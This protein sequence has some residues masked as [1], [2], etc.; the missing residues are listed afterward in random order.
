MTIDESSGRARPECI[1]LPVRAGATPAGK[2]TVRIFLG[3]E[4]AQFRANRVFLWSIE[5]VRDPGREYEIYFMSEL[6]GFDRHGWTTGFTNY[7]FAIPHLAGERG[8]AIYNDEDQIYLRDPGELFDLDLDG[9]G[10]L[11]ISDTETSVMLIDCERMAKLWTLE[12]AQRVRKKAILRKTLRVPRIRGELDPHWNARDEEFVAGRSMCLHYT[13]LHMQPWRPFPERFAYL[14]NPHEDLWLE[15]ERSSIAAGYDIFERRRPTQGF[16]EGLACLERGETRRVGAPAVQETLARDLRG[17]VERSGARS[18]LEVAPLRDDGENGEKASRVEVWNEAPLRATLT[19]ASL[20]F[21]REA[22]H[23]TYDGVACTG[24]LD[25][26]PVEDVAWVV[27]ELFRHARSF[28]FAAVPSDPEPPRPRRGFPPPGTVYTPDWWASHFENAATRHP[29]VH[30]ELALVSRRDTRRGESYYRV[31]GHHLGGNPRVWVLC[32]DRPGNTTQSMGLAEALGWPFGS[33]ELGFSTLADIPNPLMGASLRGLR[34]DVR[35]R[36]VPPWPDLVI[37]AGRRT[38][39]VARWIG[40]QSRGRTRLVQLGRKGAN[41]AARFDLAVTPRYA[42]LIP[43][44]RRLEIAAPLTRVRADALEQAGRDWKG[45]FDGAASPRIALLVGGESQRHEFTP[46][47]ASR[48]GHEVAEMA[49]RLGGSVFATTSRRTSEEAAAALDEA[50]AGAVHIHHWSPGSTTQENPYLGYLALADVL[51]VTG[52]S[53]SMVA[54]ACATG[55][56]VCIYP[57]KKRPRGVVFDVADSFIDAVVKRAYARPL[58]NRGTTRPQQRLEYLCARWIERGFVRPNRDLDDFHRGLEEQGVAR[59]FDGSLPSG[60]PN[61][62][63]ESVRVA[64]RVR[65]LMGMSS[66]SGTT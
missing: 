44:P 59:I 20:F 26:L 17:L 9:H 19:S 24:G 5:Q 3:T 21:G 48:L 49:H 11:A 50:L 43:H 18:L 37:A 8:R 27:E 61:A 14:S 57:L 51:V 54:E 64:S 58:N 42:Q 34:D 31:G 36:L 39:P 4:P 45:L 53:E 52:E 22:E 40:E 25:A 46:E 28:V 62:Y 38:A 29:E 23:E 2:P 6:A 47:D 32:D 56:P 63:S 41:P 7:R 66:N 60:G 10:F 35:R 30:W 1:R 55:K 13:T 16:A 33:I 12:D 65:A 15:L